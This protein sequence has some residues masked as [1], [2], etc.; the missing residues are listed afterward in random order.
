MSHVPDR[1]IA[2]VQREIGVGRVQA[3]YICKQR[4]NLQEMARRELQASVD[5]CVQRYAER[6]QQG[7]APC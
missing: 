5:R 6:N 3:F 2:Q 1:E 7:A 4:R